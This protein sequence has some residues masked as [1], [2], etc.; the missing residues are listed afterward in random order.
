MSETKYAHL[1]GTE[2]VQSAANTMKE[3]AHEMQRA[4]NTIHDA[5][6][7]HE[8]K[9]CDALYIHGQIMIEAM[10]ELNRLEAKGMKY[11]RKSKNN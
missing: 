3:A 8:E 6:Q 1:I 2:Q 5:L 4:A 7:R 10:K 11:D 9:M